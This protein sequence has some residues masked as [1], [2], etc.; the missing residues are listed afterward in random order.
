MG[1]NTRPDQ[2]T[3]THSPLLII[4]QLVPSLA[5]ITLFALTTGFYF[6][7]PPTGMASLPLIYPNH[8]S[9]VA[10]VMMLAAGWLCAAGD[11]MQWTRLS[12]PF[13][14]VAWFLLMMAMMSAVPPSVTL[15][16][17]K[18]RGGQ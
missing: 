5:L 8:G 13:L 6:S 10:I 3:P 7:V 17:W 14:F 11:G 18:H 4:R 12:R 15:G 1:W 16:P 9:A 2:V